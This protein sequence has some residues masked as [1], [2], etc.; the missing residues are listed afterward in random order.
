MKAGAVDDVLA[1][2]RAIAARADFSTTKGLLL[3]DVGK[4]RI[5]QRDVLLRLRNRYDRMLRAYLRE[6][7]TTY[8]AWCD[9]GPKGELDEVLAA[10]RDAAVWDR[11]VDKHAPKADAR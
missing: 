11:L 7:G 2:Q 5:T 1:R 8:E 10:A 9:H 3:R 4:E 6:Q